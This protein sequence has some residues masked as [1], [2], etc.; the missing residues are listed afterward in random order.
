MP[1]DLVLRRFILLGMTFAP[2]VLMLFHPWP[3]D[4]YSNEL[5]PIAACSLNIR[6]RSYCS[7]S[8]QRPSGCQQTDC[9]EWPSSSAASGPWS[10]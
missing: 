3:Y 10:L 4:G 7:R 2:A 6:W 5:A 8:R 9:R 1:L